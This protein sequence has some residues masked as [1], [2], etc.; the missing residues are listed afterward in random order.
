MVLLS[1][2][3]GHCVK[4]LALGPSTQPRKQVWAGEKDTGNPTLSWRCRWTIKVE[5]CRRHLNMW[6]LGF[7]GGKVGNQV[8]MR[9][10]F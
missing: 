1:S 7:K 3:R 9:R 10:I 5:V 8:K 4:G 6:G 2:G